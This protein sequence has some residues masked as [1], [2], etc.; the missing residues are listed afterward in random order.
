MAVYDNL[1]ISPYPNIE[2]TSRIF[3]LFLFSFNEFER[4]CAGYDATEAS[5]GHGGA[6]CN[7]EGQR[8]HERYDEAGAGHDEAGY[9]YREAGC[10]GHDADKIFGYS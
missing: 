8:H 6:R 10:K 7:A 3:F 4:V 9:Y 5:E 2:L 1:Y